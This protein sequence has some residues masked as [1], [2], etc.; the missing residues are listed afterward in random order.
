MSIKKDMANVPVP[1][2]PFVFS[3][4]RP[5]KLTESAY[6]LVSIVIDATSSV[7]SFEKDLLKAL[8]S[9]VDACRSSPRAENLLI[10][11]TTFNESE[12]E[13]HGFK[14]LNEINTDDYVSIDPQGMTAL[15]DA[16]ASAIGATLTLSKDLVYNQEMDVNG[17]VVVITDGEDNRSRS[18]SPKD[19]KRLIEAAAQ[20]EIIESLN[21]I[22]IGVNS[23]YCGPALKDFQ[24]KSGIAQY[25]DAGDA[26]S[27]NLA[28]V[29]DF[30]SRSISST[31][32]SLGTGG[33]SQALTF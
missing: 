29:A 12:Y 2:T 16:T 18:A 1:N 14:P 26:S 5:E 30:V 11:V 6:S 3:A 27:K 9:T 10:R 28:K 19:I 25:V 7:S 21:T 24:N 32:V 20:E 33:P 23:D 17:L 4:I 31:S 13:I 8:K 15:Y 22:L